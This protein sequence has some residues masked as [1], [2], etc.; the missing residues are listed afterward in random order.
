[1]YLT[2]ITPA[3]F[4]FRIW[5]LIYSLLI[6]SVIVMIIKKDDDYYQNAVDEITG[7]FRVS[8]ILNMAWI[9]AFSYVQ[10]ELSVLLIFAFLATL[11]LICFKLR[12]IQIKKQF[13]LPLT[14]GLY[15]GWLFIASFVNLA[16][17]FVKLNWSFFG[18]GNEIVAISM[19]VIVIIL[20]IVAQSQVRNSVF[21]LPIAWAHWG[22]YVFLKAPNGFNGEFNILQITAL[23][24]MAFLTFMSLGCFYR[25][26][27]SII[28]DSSNSNR[29]Y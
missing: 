27:F 1:M 21:P 5:S 2:L 24:G 20:T 19:I 3:P 6:I 9:F 4:T 14:F 28:Q 12:R 11:L 13:L 18:I 15:T 17:L 16:A 7:L 25:N 26:N 10:I 22:I 23:V 29:I 8:C